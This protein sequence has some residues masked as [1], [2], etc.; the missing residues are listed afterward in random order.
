MQNCRIWKLIIIII[1]QSLVKS[2]KVLS[3]SLLEKE[4]FYVI[5]WVGYFPCFLKK[6]IQILNT[7]QRHTF[8]ALL[9]RAC[10]LWFQAKNLIAPNLQNGISK[11]PK[12]RY[13]FQSKKSQEIS[14]EMLWFWDKL[15]GNNKWNFYLEHMQGFFF[16]NHYIII[17]IGEYYIYRNK[18]IK[19]NIQL[20]ILSPK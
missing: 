5:F 10:S 12:H 4:N 19:I 13:N 6:T 3:G 14:L 16:D 15:H 1:E 17:A 11:D 8:L 2:I 9:D 20:I 18:K 7:F